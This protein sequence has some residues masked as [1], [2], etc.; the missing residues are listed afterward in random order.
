MSA[1]NILQSGSITPGHLS[2]WV[3]DGVLKDA[4]VPPV[5][6]SP[7][8]LIDGPIITPDFS[9]GINFSLTLTAAG[10]TF[11]NPVNITVGQTGIIYFIQD[12]SGFRTITS[13]GGYYK[14]AAGVKPVLSTGAN[15][16]DT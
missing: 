15:A 11:A 5:P 12:N 2:T 9:T 14:F 10:R 8:V 7:V 13:W 3:T 16:I 1:G 4:G 6:I